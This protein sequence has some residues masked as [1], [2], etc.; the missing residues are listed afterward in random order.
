[1][2]THTAD[3]HT[4]D[5]HTADTHTEDTHTADTH[6]PEPPGGQSERPLWA[7]LE[8]VRDQR[9]EPNVKEET[10]RDTTH[11]EG[12]RYITRTVG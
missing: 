3:T 8:S 6:T 2:D 5:T 4:Q 1:M 10:H 12:Y 11:G 9:D 7:V